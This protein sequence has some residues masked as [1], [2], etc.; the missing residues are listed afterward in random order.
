MNPA[1]SRVLA[2]G[3]CLLLVLWGSACGNARPAAPERRAPSVARSGLVADSTTA[4][5]RGFLDGFAAFSEGGRDAHA[6]IEIPAGTSAKWMIRSSDGAFFWERQNGR[7]RVVDYLAYPVN[8]GIVPHTRAWDGDP[9]DVLV[10]GSALPRGSVWQVRP[11]GVLHLT[12]DGARDDKILTV[13]PGSPLGT[14]RDLEG[15]REAYPGVT[16][17]LRTWFTHYKG[18]GGTLE[19]RG[20]GD[21]DEARQLIH[22]AEETY[23]AP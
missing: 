20:Y 11:I 1:G 12:D 22:E 3:L 7:R 6:V 21:A 15:L 4:A 2:S 5:R 9:L 17:I 16:D 14:V 10:L 18:S 8:Y 23:E 19:S 13:R